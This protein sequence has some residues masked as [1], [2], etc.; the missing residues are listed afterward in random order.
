MAE[1]D[2]LMYYL[3]EFIGMS[4]DHKLAHAITRCKSDAAAM[5]WAYEPSLPSHHE[6]VAYEADLRGRVLS[7]MTDDTLLDILEKH[8]TAVYRGHCLREH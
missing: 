7:G 8:G 6:R 1:K 2:N 3:V 4:R 5:R